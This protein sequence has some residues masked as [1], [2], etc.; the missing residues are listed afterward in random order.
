MTGIHLE[1]LAA[2]EANRWDEL[3][4][5]YASRHLFHR[6]VWLDYLAA[7]RGLEIRK[8][9]IMDGRRRL[10]YFCGGLVRKGPFRVL[11]SPL[12]GWGTNY[13]GPVV[14]RDIDQVRL[15]QALDDLARREG[16]AMTELESPALPSDLLQSS[17]FQAVRGWTYL[18]CL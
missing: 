5:P 18:V 14:R 10:G 3:V 11:G 9:S 1:P 13:M 6:Q 4:T 2:E 8:W 7:S 15:I 17:G 12:K 16:L